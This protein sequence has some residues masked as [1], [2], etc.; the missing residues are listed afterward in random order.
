MDRVRCINLDVDYRDT[1]FRNLISYLNYKMNI[2]IIILLSFAGIGCILLG[3]GVGLGLN[4]KSILRKLFSTP[5]K[6][7]SNAANK[8]RLK[9]ILDVLP[10]LTLEEQNILL[11]HLFGRVVK[12]GRC[13]S[14]DGKYWLEYVMPFGDEETIPSHLSESERDVDVSVG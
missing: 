1:D 8:K 13:F 6:Y 4:W 2:P 14:P 12:I 10:D 9:K 11:L 3:L 7:R 5:K